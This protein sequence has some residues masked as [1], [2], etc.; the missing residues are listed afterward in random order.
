MLIGEA[1]AGKT[2]IAQGI[3]Q[4]IVEKKVAKSLLGKRV[5]LLD[6]TAVVAGTTY[7]GE[8]EERMKKI[9]K[10]CFEAKN[11]I[12][13]IDEIHTM[14][15]A[16]SASGS[17]DAANILKPA[18][19]DGSLQA[20]GATTLKEYREGIESDTALTRRF[21]NVIVDPTSIEDTIEIL[22]GLKA[23]YEKF[24]NVTYTEESL[25]ACVRL[26]DRFITDRV[27]P[28]KAIDLMDEAGARANAILPEGEFTMPQEITD[29]LNE[30]NRLEARKIELKKAQDYEACA[31]IRDAAQEIKAL[32]D[33]KKEEWEN[34]VKQKNNFS[35]ITVDTIQEIVQ[36]TTGV[37]VTKMNDKDL[38]ELRNMKPGMMRYVIGQETAVDRVVMAVKRSRLGLKK[39]NR[40]ISL[41]F[42]GV[43]GTGKTHLARA[44][45]R[46]VFGSEDNFFKIDMSEYQEK[47][48]VSRLIGAPPGYVGYEEGG[49]LTEKVR[50]KP[51]S[52]I[53]LDEIE[54][55]HP[56]I[57][58]LLLQALEDGEITDGLKRKCSLKNTIIIMTSNVGVTK[59]RDFGVGVGFATTARSENSK[60]MENDVLNK[61]L[62]KKF[63]P[64]FLNRIDEVIYFNSLERNDIMAITKLEVNEAIS[65]VEKLGF[66]VDYELEVLQF[67][68]DRGFDKEMGARPLYRTIQKHIE[69]LVA[70]DLIEEKIKEGDSITFR[71]EEDKIVCRI[72]TKDR[73][74]T[75]QKS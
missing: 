7:R 68:A 48:T 41:L 31:S 50:R 26:S 12:L 29:L 52:V 27:L 54:K 15:G 17:M 64:E 25:I 44:L 30:F 75:R 18:L 40:P 69:D 51:W 32:Y 56:D 19:A 20:I 47:N 33:E 73:I 46:E 14:V 70:E 63:S 55:A 34:D 53:L 74:A 67:I 35:N 37:P 72:N 2:Q 16:G 42:I 60:K 59:L 3:A 23:I 13:F 24:H 28:D 71:V 8:F 57:Y 1:G 38:K 66:E 36:Q 11:I 49:Q 6:L 58:N 10:D 65:R 5:I 22:K 61:E 39:A 9:V 43:T 62:K 4:R 45:A 21:Q